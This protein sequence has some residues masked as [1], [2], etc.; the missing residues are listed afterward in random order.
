MVHIVSFSGVDGSG[1]S[2]Q[3]RQVAS[4]LNQLG[5]NATYN[6]PTYRNLDAVRSYCTEQYGSPYAYAAEFAPEIYMGALISDWLH[7]KQVLVPEMPQDA[8]LCMDRYAPDVMAQAIRHGA[9]FGAVAAIM[10][11]FP[12]TA[13]SYLM[14]IDPA[15]AGNRLEARAE[16]PRNPLENDTALTL[17]SQGLAEARSIWPMTAIDATAGAQEI[18][19]RITA[20]VAEVVRAAQPLVGAP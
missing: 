12:S 10:A 6:T 17:L 5:F 18:T 7:W 16:D 15:V 13:K 3:A 4:A 9:S 14:D 20:E 19:A 11:N 2:T 1:K 8:V